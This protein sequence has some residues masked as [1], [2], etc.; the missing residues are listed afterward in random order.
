M[1]TDM[2]Y[3]QLQQDTAALTREILHAAAAIQNRAQ[4]MAEEANDTGRL[5]ETIS[6]LKV[7][8]STVAETRELAAITAGLSKAAIAYATAGNTTAKAAQAVADQAKDSH[9]GINEAV[10]RSGVQGIHDVN[11][12]WFTQE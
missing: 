12:S 7:D 3:K 10:N 9:S 1:A 2:T 11:R 4:Q 6:A 8:S 5:A